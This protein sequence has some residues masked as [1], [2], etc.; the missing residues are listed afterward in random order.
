MCLI[1]KYLVGC[2]TLEKFTV[3]LRFVFQTDPSRY[4]GIIVK[5]RNPPH[6][7]NT[8]GRIQNL[9]LCNLKV[10]CSAD[11]SLGKPL[12]FSETFPHN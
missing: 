11:Y 6:P 7:P 9:K 5:H 10:S 2:L 4:P 12:N 1:K 8:S 3:Q